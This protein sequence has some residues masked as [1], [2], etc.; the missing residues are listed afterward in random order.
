MNPL[1]QL[2]SVEK[3]TVKLDGTT[4]LPRALVTG[5][6]K[7][8][9]AIWR[10]RLTTGGET[11]S[12]EDIESAITASLLAFSASRLQAV[13]NATGVLIHTNLGRSP[14]GRRSADALHQIASGYCNLEFDLPSGSR[15]SRAGY[16]ESALAILLEAEAATAVNNCAA[17]LVLTLRHLVEEGKDEVIV[18]RGE[19][20]EIGGGFRIPDVLETS[21]AKLIE[22]GATNKT[23]LRDYA[24]AIGPRTALI[25]KVHRSNFY[26]EGFTD[27]P[28]VPDLAALAREHGLLLVE[29]LGSGAV[30]NTDE[31]APLDHEPTPQEALRNGIDLVIF[32]GDKLLG[33]PQAG[34]IAGRA[35]LVAAI[36]QEPFFR[37][38]RCDKLILTVLQECIDDYLQCKGG[39]PPDLPT[40]TF[41]ATPLEELRTRAEAIVADLPTELA[42]TIDIVKAT[43]RT[44]GGTMPKSQIPSLALRIT[45]NKSVD[46]LAQKLRTGSPPVIGYTEEDAL[47]LN[48]RTIFPHQDQALAQALRQALTPH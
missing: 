22:V 38:V 2:P 17:A 35:E 40:L 36:K 11:S 27:E 48:L 7:R 47:H 25:L 6:I 41:L 42:A 29:D 39:S 3:L 33:G 23:H 15:G 4:A 28:A 24:Q 31:L 1:S 13:L 44:G 46:S 45:P 16:L 26:I 10:E 5:L 32:S 12:R 19:L 37:A 34:I 18:S 21:G 43:S 20:V 14:Q 30:M 9:V 8:E